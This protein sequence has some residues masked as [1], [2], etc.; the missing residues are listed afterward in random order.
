LEKIYEDDMTVIVSDKC[1][2]YISFQ[3]YDVNYTVKK[4]EITAI[5]Y[6]MPKLIREP[7]IMDAVCIKLQDRDPV[8]IPV[9]NEERGTD[10]MAAI[11][12]SIK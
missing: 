11:H 5:S 2:L 3:H 8:L 1:S 9:L 6:V 7:R 12:T 4:D 10:I